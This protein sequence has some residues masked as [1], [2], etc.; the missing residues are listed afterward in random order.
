MF[1]SDNYMD[2]LIGT[3][4][5]LSANSFC[6]FVTNWLCLYF[7]LYWLIFKVPIESRHR[8]HGVRTYSY[9]TPPPSIVFFYRTT[10]PIINWTLEKP[11][12]IN[13]V[14][15]RSF[16]PL[17]RNNKNR[18]SFCISLGFSKTRNLRQNEVLLTHNIMNISIF[19]KRGFS[20]INVV[21]FV[22][23]A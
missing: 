21:P 20:T 1:N 7:Q 10:P 3:F 17:N 22:R 23:K 12:P 15:L 18:I 2:P 19:L 13:S 8:G 16:A 11:F 6:S 5:R 4:F 14:M 9:L